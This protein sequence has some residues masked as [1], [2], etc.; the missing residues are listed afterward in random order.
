MPTTPTRR[1]VATQA[2][3]SA[4][5]ISP[6]AGWLDYPLSRRRFGFLLATAAA[7]GSMALASAANTGAIAPPAIYDLSDYPEL[8]IV[9]T[10]TALSMPTEIAAGRYLVTNENQTTL[11]ESAPNIIL[12]PEGRETDELLRELNGPDVAANGFPD[13]FSTTSI[14]GVP[15]APPGTTVRGVIDLPPGRYAVM[16]EEFQPHV[17]LVVLPETDEMLPEPVARESVSIGD[18]AI[19]G[20]PERTPAGSYLWRVTATGEAP[21]RFQIYRYAEPITLDG[22]LAGLTLAE[23]EALPEGALDMSQVEQLGGMG[24]QSGGLTGWALLDLEP[25]TY[26]ALCSM[27]D[28][29]ESPMH[30]LLGE[31][32]VFT[33]DPSPFVAAA[34]WR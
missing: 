5:A 24:L 1:H 21:H 28:G 17:T 12:L 7:T 19:T 10:D 22:V 13:W 18:G 11:G 34:P 6:A 15:V 8:H 29:E 9:A 3:T 25:G 14:I 2:G 23:G 16:G 20:V 27:Q 4:A 33:V 30:G 32:A 31:I 26:I